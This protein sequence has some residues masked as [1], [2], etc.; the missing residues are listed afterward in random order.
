M[1]DWS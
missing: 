1:M